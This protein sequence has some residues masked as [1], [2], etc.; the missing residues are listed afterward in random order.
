MGEGGGRVA[1]SQKPNFKVFSRVNFGQCIL[2]SLPLQLRGAHGGEARNRARSGR[3]EQTGLD[4]R[5][6]APVSE[7]RGSGE[8]TVSCTA[9]G[10][11]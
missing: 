1:Q 11:W 2:N 8:V 5:G 6:Q 4:R 9:R 7:P 3:A 10:A